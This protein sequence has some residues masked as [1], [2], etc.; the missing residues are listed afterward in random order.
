MGTSVV[1]KPLLWHLP[2]S[3]FSEKVRWALD[4]KR[5]P[6]RR[7]VAQPGLHPLYAVVLTRGRQVTI[8][9]LELDGQVV[10]GDSAAIIAELERRWPEP[11]LYPSGDADRT[12]ALELE[13]WFGENLGHAARAWVF[14]ELTT[15]PESLEELTVKQLEPFAGPTPPF[16]G[17][18]VR[19]FV[20]ARYGVGAASAAEE[21]RRKILAALDRLEGELRGG[22][23]LVGERFSVADLTA[24]ALFYPVVQP[25]GAPWVIREQPE[26]MVEFRASLADR[27]GVRWVEETWRRWR[28]PSG[29]PVA[30]PGGLAAT[31]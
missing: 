6:H 17:A 20:G 9:V 25:D 30:R 18:V 28:R 29:P 10:A 24:A 15:H 3:H 8:P 11:P 22:E 23:F 1:E 13:A 26:G 12:R 4:L 16:A 5:V 19:R 2:I 21:A 31:V 7:R 27:P 14:Y